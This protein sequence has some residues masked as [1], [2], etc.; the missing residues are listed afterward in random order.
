MLRSSSSSV[1]MD[2]F[3]GRVHF[4]VSEWLRRGGDDGFHVEILY[5]TTTFYADV[6]F[7]LLFFVNTKRA[8]LWYT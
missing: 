2:E 5:I 7:F 1:S 4:A 8:K 3:G 6:A